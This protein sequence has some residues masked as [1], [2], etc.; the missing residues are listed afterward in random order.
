MKLKELKIE[1]FRSI[2]NEKIIFDDYTCLVGANGCGKS[3]LLMALN[4]FFRNSVANG[5][6]VSLSKEDFHHGNTSDPIKITLTFV[7]LSEEAKNDF[8]EYFRQEKLIVSAKAIWD[9]ATQTAPV[10]QCGSRL[11]M[12]D[13]K[14]YFAKDKAGEKAP[15]LKE[16]YKS[17]REKYKD[18][19]AANSKP[20]ME[21]ALRNYEE[22]HPELCEL[23]ESGDQFYGF[24]RGAD[25]LPKYVQWVYIPAIKDP[26]SEQE[27]SKKTALGQLLDRTVRTKVNFKDH[28]DLLKKELSEKYEKIISNEKDAL[29]QLG[30]SLGVRLKEWS[31][32]GAKVELNWNYDK[33]KSVSIAEPLARISIGEGNFI[34]EIFRLGH[35]IQRS[36]LIALLQELASSADANAPTLILGFE[37]PEIFQHPPQARHMSNLLENLASLNSQIIVTT[38][39]PYFVPGRGFQSVRMI[40]KDPKTFESHVSYLS[41]EDLELRI[42][43]ALGEQPKSVSAL[44]AGIEQIMQPSLK[45]IFFCP[46]AILVEGIEDIAFISTYMNLLGFWNDFRKYG[47]HFILAG[48]KT[49]LSRPLAIASLFGVPVFTVF[50]ADTDK[51]KKEEIDRNV[52]DNSCILNLCE[53]NKFDPLSKSVIWERNVTMWPV[54]F[55]DSV[56]ES[57]GKDFWDAAKLK[58]LKENEW[59]G[60]SG[61]NSL[62]IT[63]TIEVLWKDGKRSDILERL[64]K[65]IIDFS[66]IS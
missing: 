34:G 24:T 19:P 16:F 36:F 8:K 60:V 45:E 10:I 28:I 12:S 2:K 6:I 17:L 9:G 43:K 54:N 64:C 46:V 55:S 44:V 42:S 7:D 58:I 4:V 30:E 18:L 38:H 13:F 5:N 48:G 32:P 62:V 33:E 52:K 66:K 1:N 41:I 35:G 22:K 63:A 47:C 49:N 65:A 11:V 53:L 26:S 50:D 20:E 37:E 57:Y 23:G 3:T 15:A 31:H 25:R 14:A 40:R 29:R 27:E 39:S 61:K 21:E 51:T 56:Q 59:E